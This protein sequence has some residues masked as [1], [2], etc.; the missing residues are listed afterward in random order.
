[1]EIKIGIIGT[2]W[3]TKHHLNILARFEEVVV[4]GF[5]GSNKEKAEH[6][7]ASYPGTKGFGSLD[8]MI[9]D[10]RP[11]AV[12]ICVPPMGHGHYEK[13]LI[14]EGIPFF[15]EKPL[16][17]D[18]Q[19]VKEI[20]QLAE[21]RNH[22]T[23]VG[24]QFR[25]S[26]TVEKWKRYNKRVRT[27]MVT[28]GWMGSM[29][30]V[31][32]WRD[33][34]SS[35]GQFNEQTTHLVDLIRFVYGEVVSVYAKETQNGNAKTD[36]SISVAD[37]G[38]YTLTMES[39]LIVHV[40]NTS[41]L[42]DGIGEVDIKA[43]TDKGILTWQIQNFEALFG[44]EKESF[45]AKKDPYIEE[46]AAFIYAVINKDSSKILSSYQDA[47]QS[48]KVAMAARKSIESGREVLLTDIE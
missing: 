11:D 37:V 48:F 42:P 8:E 36:R 4:V 9:A 21:E 20:N 28:A 45:T 32:W 15:V 16:G 38:S 24:Y 1:M 34:S 39:G 41:V 47:F 44:N 35:G 33:Q 26:D 5:V 12:Y 30:P 13:L 14:E 19:T 46:N 29:P 40:S 7:A 18:I 25:Y 27:G 6:H 17:N 23:S 3:F 31:Y 10:D 2:G 22:L 43:Y